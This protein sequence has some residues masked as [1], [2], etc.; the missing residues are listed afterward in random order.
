MKY[1]V[2]GWTW[3]DD[4]STPDAEITF[5]KKYAVIDEVKKK[6][7]LFSG[8]DHQ[9][10]LGCAPILN[11]GTKLCLSR[12]GW[13]GVMA[14][15]H[16]CFGIYDYARFTDRMPGSKD[17]KYPIRSYYTGIDKKLEMRE[18]FDLE[19]T[20]DAQYDAFLK[21]EPIS[22][23]DKDSPEIYG[24]LRYLDKYDGVR[25][26]RGKRSFKRT[27]ANVEYRKLYTEA[28]YQA[29]LNYQASPE[30]AKK[31][32]EEWLAIPTRITIEFRR[33]GK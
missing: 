26:H 6:G 12:R 28:Q 10:R 15:A 31:A 21:G 19:A 13:G 16:D 22:F 11:D 3:A 20:D 30:E 1:R 25:L 33:K 29:C 23:T 9:D 7:Y 32:Y 4:S 18:T 27:V 14:E 17:N 8:E 24:S 5:A 2:V